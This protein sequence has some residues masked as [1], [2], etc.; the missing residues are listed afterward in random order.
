[1]IKGGGAIKNVPA[2][3]G[4]RAAKSRGLGAPLLLLGSHP[5]DH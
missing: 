2:C 1:M 4:E 3:C 5:P